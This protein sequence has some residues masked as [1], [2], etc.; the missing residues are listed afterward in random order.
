MKGFLLWLTFPF[1]RQMKHLCLL[2]LHPWQMILNISRIWLGGLQMLQMTFKEVT[3]P[4]HKLFGIIHSPSS[5]CRALPVNEALL[6]PVKTI[7]HT[8]ASILP[9]YKRVDK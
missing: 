3:E 9:T 4:H 6:N 1:H 5:T 2:L 7:W 8:P